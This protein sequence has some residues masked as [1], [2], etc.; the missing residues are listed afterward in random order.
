[1]NSASYGHSCERAIPICS[2][3]PDCF[4]D[5][6]ASSTERSCRFVRRAGID[7]SYSDGDVFCTGIGHSCRSLGSRD[8]RMGFVKFIRRGRLRLIRRLRFGLTQ[9]VKRTH[10]A[11]WTRCLCRRR[12]STWTCSRR[13]RSRIQRIWLNVVTC[14]LHCFV[15]QM[16]PVPV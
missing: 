16:R 8:W 3:S 9:V 13:R 7:V 10:V 11:Q 4:P 1:M 12:A 5:A 15:T 14:Q 6:T 2:Q